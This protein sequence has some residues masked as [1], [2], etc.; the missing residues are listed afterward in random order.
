MPA[1][2]GLQCHLTDFC[3]GSKTETAPADLQK[4]Q[5]PLEAPLDEKVST[6]SVEGSGG[7]EH[8]KNDFERNMSSRKGDQGQQ[9]IHAFDL[10]VGERIGNQI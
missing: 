9:D 1:L 8:I 10:T 2:A 4:L 3:V 7:E 5:L 6:G